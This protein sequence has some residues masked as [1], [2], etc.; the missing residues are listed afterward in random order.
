MRFPKMSSLRRIMARQDC[1][2]NSVLNRTVSAGRGLT[3]DAV[4]VGGYFPSLRPYS[5]ATLGGME[6]GPGP[7]GA[8]SLPSTTKNVLSM[9]LSKNNFGVSRRP[10]SPLP[11]SRLRE[12]GAILGQPLACPAAFARHR[13]TPCPFTTIGRR[14]NVRITHERARLDKP[15]AAPNSL[16]THLSPCHPPRGLTADNQ[17]DASFG[18][19]SPP[20][21][22]LGLLQDLKEVVVLIRP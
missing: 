3:A 18:S 7:S 9:R 6:L 4:P 17:R 15:A 21:F 5:T 13:E 16:I 10:P 12:R 1:T 8:A 20:L 19:R 22:N 11:L 14:S 2:H